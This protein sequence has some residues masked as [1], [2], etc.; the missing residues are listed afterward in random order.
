MRANPELV[1]RDLR[2]AQGEMKK[3]I[4]ILVFSDR[5]SGDAR[6]PLPTRVAPRPP[7]LRCDRPLGD[8]RC[9]YVPTRWQVMKSVG[10]STTP[11][12]V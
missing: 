9:P 11:A 5:P 2:F 6:C 3:G 4:K 7:Q 12:V 8:A 10:A 1:H